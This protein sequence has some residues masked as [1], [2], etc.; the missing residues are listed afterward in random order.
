MNKKNAHPLLETGASENIEDVGEKCR[1]WYNPTRSLRFQILQVKPACIFP[2]NPFEN[3]KRGNKCT[4]WAATCNNSHILALFAT[5]EINNIS[6]SFSDDDFRR[7]IIK[8]KHCL[9][10]FENKVWHVMDVDFLHRFLHKSKS[11]QMPFDSLP[12]LF[13]SINLLAF[14]MQC[15]FFS[16]NL[17]TF[18]CL[19]IYCRFPR[20]IY[21]IHIM[22]QESR[23]TDLLRSASENSSCK[24]L[25]PG[26]QN[27][28]F[29]HGKNCRMTS[30][31]SLYSLSYG[32]LFWWCS[33]G[34]W[35]RIWDLKNKA[36]SLAHTSFH[37][38]R[39]F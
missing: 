9:V 38:A 15:H 25:Q 26:S 16:G 36:V 33:L 4:T 14:S 2:W 22:K 19:Q 20:M 8:R 6:N 18:P 17:K 7:D 3:N 30:R 24:I 21:I 31:F 27:V 39:N 34:L 12:V 1:H 29:P 32:I 11:R 28:F 37:Y 23:F 5:G 10:Y 35:H 13:L